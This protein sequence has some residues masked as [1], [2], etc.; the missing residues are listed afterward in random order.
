MLS[1]L[2][3]AVVC[4]AAAAGQAAG[5]LVISTFSDLSCTAFAGNITIP[6]SSASSPQCWAMSSASNAAIASLRGSNND[7]PPPV[8]YVGVSSQAKTGMG[9]YG[10]V[11]SNGVC[12]LLGYG[13]TF[14]ASSSCYAST[15]ACSQS[16]TFAGNN[17]SLCVGS[18][19]CASGCTPPTPT[20]TP[21]ATAAVS[22]LPSFVPTTASMLYISLFADSQCSTSAYS[23]PGAAGATG[24]TYWSAI[25]GT[26]TVGGNGIFSGNV[27]MNW[28]II[29]T[30]S[31][32][33][34]FSDAACTVL[35]GA[36]SISSCVACLPGTCSAVSD[37]L[38]GVP[39]SIYLFYGMQNGIQGLPSGPQFARVFSVPSTCNSSIYR[40]LPGM[41]V[42]GP[43]VAKPMVL[44]SEGLCQV[45]CCATPLCSAY[46]FMASDLNIGVA[47]SGYVPLAS[48]FLY[49]NITALVPSSGMASGA[50]YSAYS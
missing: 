17:P 1:F 36:A 43:L 25:A 11:Y 30:S 23:S 5:Q 29:S 50:L 6:F 28:P 16:N 37:G 38:A 13:T 20:L 7:G 49:A 14:F 35:I 48:C 47:T 31:A 12:P 21:S 39:P 19:I 2:L 27:P 40:P 32:I 44:Q 46:S 3:K 15:A 8:Q 26:C 34:S 4:F 24:A 18:Y 9:T 33:Y 42:F 45:A 10:A 41:D 22:P